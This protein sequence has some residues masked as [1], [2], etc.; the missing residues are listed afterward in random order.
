MELEDVTEQQRIV[1]ALYAELQARSDRVRL[2]ETHI[3]F[4]LLTGEYAYKI[5]KAIRLGFLD[6]RALASRR[7]FCEEEVRLNRRLAPALYLDVVRITGVASAP[8]DV[9]R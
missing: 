4:V 3:S 7:F 9:Q 2:V 6:F 1:Q 8:V 5:K